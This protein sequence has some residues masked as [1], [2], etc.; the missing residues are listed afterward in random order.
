MEIIRELEKEWMQTGRPDFAGGGAHV[1]DRRVLKQAEIGLVYVSQ[2]LLGERFEQA[3]P[4]D[5]VGQT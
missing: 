3:G 2:T 1:V 4:H 5:L